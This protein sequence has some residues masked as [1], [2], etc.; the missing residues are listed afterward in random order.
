MKATPGLRQLPDGRWRY[1]IYSAGTKSGPRV[2][3]TLPKG[4]TRTE[5]EAAYR[6]DVAKA[7]A[8][9]GRPIPRRLT[10]KDAAEEYLAVQKLRLADGTYPNLER[11]AGKLVSLFGPRP[12]ASLRPSDVATYQKAR[13]SEGVKA[14]TINVE[15][16]WFLAIVRKMVAF[17]WLD[18]DPL[19]PGAVESLPTPA[20]KTEFFRPEEWEA[21]VEA[22]EERRPEA[23]DV[24]RALLLTATRVGELVSLTWGGVDLAAK[25]ITFEM[26]KKRG[27]P[28]SLPITAELAE[29]LEA[30]PRGI[31]KAR[32]FTRPDGTPWTTSQLRT[33]FYTARDAAKLRKSLTVHSCRHTAASWA[34]QAG[35]PLIKIKESLGHSN[36][37]QT[38]R[39]S[40][41]STEH[42]SEAVEAVAAVEKSRRRHR[43][44]TDRG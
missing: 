5:A 15:V 17:G 4:T 12:V 26:S 14:S 1:R 2:Q 27:E 39:Y 37:S 38:V 32:V 29:I 9:R 18:R 23:V 11:T 33:V 16:M 24:F 13:L 7:A 22:L 30:L 19:P 3:V 40:H 21:F 36:L 43:G 35:V 42:L 34:A 20:P 31:G 41:L 6:A 10:F 44:A 28:K 8:R 25:R